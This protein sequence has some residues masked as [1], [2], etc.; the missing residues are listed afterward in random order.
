M[1]RTARETLRNSLSR[2][3]NRQFLDATMAATALV[4]TADGEV[5]FS[6]LSALDSVLESVQDL[7]IY[8]PHIAVD[9]YRDFA[10]A[11]AEDAESGR[12]AA[13]AAVGKIAGDRDAAELVIRV[14]V[15]ISK[16]DGELTPQ[17]ARSISDLCGTL[18]VPLPTA[19]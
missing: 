3:R 14:A 17:E 6:E 2:I 11:I 19:T 9:R 4:A 7:H 12:R 1:F 5:T 13:F 15:A 8:D 16:A 10:D 18:K